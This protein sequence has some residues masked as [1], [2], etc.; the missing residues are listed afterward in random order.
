MDRKES[1]W[2]DLETR[3]SYGKRVLFHSEGG[4]TV[5]LFVSKICEPVPV[6][7]FWEK[8]DKGFGYVHRGG[9]DR[10]V[11]KWKTKRGK[12]R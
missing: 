11:S 4:K 1:L 6:S 2:G 12:E 7:S 10:K 3:V 8:G 9:V 5:G